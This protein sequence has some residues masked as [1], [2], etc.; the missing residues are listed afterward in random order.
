MQEAILQA[1]LENETVDSNAQTSV[2]GAQ[3][4]QPVNK[5]STHHHSLLM[6]N[7]DELDQQFFR[8]NLDAV[9]KLKLNKGEKRALKF[10][11]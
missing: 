5:T 11:I 10:I 6:S 7:E 3:P 4:K 1:E 9:K 2:G 8:G